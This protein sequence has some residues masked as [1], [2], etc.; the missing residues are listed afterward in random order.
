MDSSRGAGRIDSVSLAGIAI[1]GALAVVLT[2][3]SQYLGLNFPLLPYLQFDLG[4]IAIFLAFFIFGPI[5]AVVASFIEFG[6]L[7]AIGE[8]TPI[9]PPL[10]LASIL[11]SLLGIWAGTFLISRL[12]KPTL[13]KAA[14]LG[15]F[16]GIL[17]RMG[18]MTVAN[19]YLIVFLSSYFSYYSLTAILAYYGHS[20]QP[21]GFT[22]NA[23]NGLEVILGVTAV[24]NALQLL[25]AAGVSFAIVR[26]PQV[27]NTR[28]AGRGPWISSYIKKKKE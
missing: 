13:G 10:K 14:E 23:S 2:T 5:P 16:L 27:R 18:A 17:A 26:L 24:F 3:V 12:R 6:T 21:L 19:Y 15:T 28:A 22:V 11:S 20:L 7:L 25:F 4:E 8:N 1:F 9:G